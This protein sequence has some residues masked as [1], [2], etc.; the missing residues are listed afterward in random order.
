MDW[1]ARAVLDYKPDVIVVIGDF[2]DMPSLSTHEKPG[3]KHTVNQNIKADFDAANEAFARFVG[4]IHREMDRLANGHRKRWTPE[5]HYLFG[6]HENRIVNCLN[7][8][9]KYEGLFG[10]DTFQTPGFK[11][12]DYLKIV[13]IDGLKYCHY[14]PMPH[15][16]KAIGGSIVSRLNNIGASFVQGHQQGFLYASKQFP[17]H[18]KH[19]LV[20]GR[21]YLENEH[22]RPEDVQNSEW[23]GIVVL[24]EVH[25][26]N[27]NG[28]TYDL[29]PLSMSYL[30]RKYA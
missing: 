9:P 12:H 27:G 26:Q 11:R 30:R 21:F 25:D 4:P 16:G 22:Y 29:M 3:S 18:I 2:A 17:D 20:C 23:N 13:T 19:G 15:S 5:C 10:L 1:A 7:A 14:F 24:N 6:N 8:E 28:A